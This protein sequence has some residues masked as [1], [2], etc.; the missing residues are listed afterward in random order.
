MI[1][2]YLILYNTIVLTFELSLHLGSNS[3]MNWNNISMQGVGKTCGH[4]L[5]MKE[6]DECICH[7]LLPVPLN[8][9]LVY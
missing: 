5:F 1:Y 4:H 9:S 2:T 6:T 7:S 3:F 8:R